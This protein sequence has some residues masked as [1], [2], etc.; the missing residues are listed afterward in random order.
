M[1]TKVTFRSLIAQTIL[2]VFLQLVYDVTV[3]APANFSAGFA[4]GD[5]SSSS[6]KKIDDLRHAAYNGRGEY[7]DAAVRRT[8]RALISASKSFLR[9]VVQHP[10]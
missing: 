6:A 7:L 4:R 9:A 8:F 5:P 10:R 1:I 3:A 2:I